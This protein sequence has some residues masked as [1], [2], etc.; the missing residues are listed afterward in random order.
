MNKETL[1]S[2][3]L[4]LLLLICSHIAIRSDYDLKFVLHFA[5]ETPT[6]KPPYF[7]NSSAISSLLKQGA[8]GVCSHFTT[9]L[10][11]RKGH[12]F[13]PMYAGVLDRSPLSSVVLLRHCKSYSV[14][15]QCPV[16]MVC[17]PAPD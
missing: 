2:V 10:L 11:F 1:T 17:D 4:V 14:T 5:I 13:S 15:W 3:Y 6:N 12:R 8:G 16:L 7:K 9:L